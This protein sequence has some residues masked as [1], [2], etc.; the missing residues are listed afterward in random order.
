MYFNLID[1]CQKLRIRKKSTLNR[2]KLRRWKIQQPT[3][4]IN[5]G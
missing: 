3:Q 2:G 1:Q 5:H 4:E